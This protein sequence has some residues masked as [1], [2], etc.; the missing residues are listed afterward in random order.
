MCTKIS[1]LYWKQVS[2]L[3]WR[4]CL[5][6]LEFFCLFGKMQVQRKSNIYSYASTPPPSLV[7]NQ[8][9]YKIFVK[10]INPFDAPYL[11]WQIPL[12]IQKALR[13]PNMV[14]F[15][16]FAKYKQLYKHTIILKHVSH[17]DIIT[18]FHL[19]VTLVSWE[20]AVVS[21][22]LLKTW[23]GFQYHNLIK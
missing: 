1:R 23:Q 20:W 9:A 4:L 16:K 5:L 14:W 3:L 13:K 15:I 10:V 8:T 6:H 11:C 17:C 2:S 12:L 22:A 21:A 18:S 7:N 19:L